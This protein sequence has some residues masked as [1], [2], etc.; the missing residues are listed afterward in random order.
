MKFFIMQWENWEQDKWLTENYKAYQQQFWDTAVLFPITVL[1][2]SR[3]S[4]NTE[5]ILNNTCSKL[6]SK[7]GPREPLNQFMINLWF[8][9]ILSHLFDSIWLSINTNR[10]Q[11]QRTL[12]Y[13]EYETIYIYNFIWNYIYSF[14]FISIFYMWNYIEKLYLYIH[15]HFHKVYVYFIKYIYIYLYL[16][17]AYIKIL[18]IRASFTLSE[19]C[20]YYNESGESAPSQ[21]FVI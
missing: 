21:V 6:V 3:L 2:P 4:R 7:Y 13:A 8:F 18:C 17:S 11:I 16:Y 19:R 9:Y 5:G 14:I 10:A 12:K 15:I 20:I 1:F